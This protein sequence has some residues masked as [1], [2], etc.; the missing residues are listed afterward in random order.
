MTHVPSTVRDGGDPET[1]NSNVPSIHVTLLSPSVLSVSG[2]LKVLC[3]PGKD[4]TDLCPRDSSEVVLHLRVGPVLV[5]H[6]RPRDSTSR[7]DTK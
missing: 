1:W 6:G 2:T 3:S 4:N 5:S 7:V